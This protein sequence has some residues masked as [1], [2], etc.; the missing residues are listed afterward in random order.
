MLGCASVGVSSL[1]SAASASHE[2]VTPAGLT[3]F[4]ES[5]TVVLIVAT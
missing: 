4:H 3:P 2:A 5:V 1:T